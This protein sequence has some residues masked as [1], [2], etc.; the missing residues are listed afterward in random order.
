MAELFDSHYFSG[1]GPV[2]IGTRDAAG[3]PAGV[4]FVGDVAAVEFPAN[5]D[6]TDILEN[7]SGNR[8]IGASFKTQT[9][10]ALRV[11]MKSAKP[12][13]LVRAIGGAVTTKA[14]GSASAEAVKGYHDKFTPLAHIKVSAV[15]VNGSGGTPTYVKDTDYTEHLAEGMIETLSTGSITEGLALEIDYDYAAQ[16]HITANPVDQDLV[17]ICP[18]INRARDSKRGRLTLY[19]INLDPGSLNAIQDGDE[20]ASMELTGK[21]LVDDLRAAGDQLFQWEME[22]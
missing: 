15:V 20:E 21:V 8:N 10:Y 19:K 6:R 11:V 5:I 9:E 16:K 12:A 4:A 17:L 13:H 2:F 7:V 1:Q 14:A 3:A 22:D 18:A